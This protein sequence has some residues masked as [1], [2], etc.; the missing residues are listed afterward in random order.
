LIERF[1]ADGPQ[2]ARD[3][4]L[5]ESL[6]RAYVEHMEIFLTANLLYVNSNIG[7]SDV[8]G[9]LSD[10]AMEKAPVFG[11]TQLTGNSTLEEIQSAI[12]HMETR[13]PDDNK[14]QIVANNVVS[15][16]V[17]IHRLNMMVIAKWTK[18]ITEYMQ[19]SAR[20]GRIEP[21]IVISVIDNRSLFE[22]TVFMDFNDYHRFMDKLVESVP[23]NRFQPNLMLRTLPGVL[24]A[25]LVVWATT[26]PWGQEAYKNGQKLRS[27]MKNPSYRAQEELKQKIIQ[28]L[29]P[30]DTPLSSFDD[31]VLEDFR[32]KL[33]AAAERITRQ[34]G[35]VPPHYGN[36]Q[37]SEILH[38]TWG[39]RPMFSLRDIE[40]QV[41]VLP[42][43]ENDYID[44]IA[45]LGS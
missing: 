26:Q 32:E 42:K 33:V 45:A 12:S 7:M 3:L 37:L 41:E 34:I 24:S 36:K 8:I 4:G 1:K 16:G 10:G 40:L 18:S 17:D 44:I 22:S 6:A 38:S 28:T 25:W 9:Y 14:R 2:T 15:H 21:G 39:T 20:A 5:E 31:R 13:A 43:N 30:P 19:V 27:A 29:D 35:D 11:I 23:I